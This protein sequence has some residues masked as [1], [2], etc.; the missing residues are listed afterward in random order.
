MQ[1]IYGNK[2]DNYAAIYMIYQHKLE[3]ARLKRV[4]RSD[5]DQLI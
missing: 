4:P 3:L 5:L 1:Q 2:K